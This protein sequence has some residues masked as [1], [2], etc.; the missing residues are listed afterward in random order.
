VIITELGP[1]NL[2]DHLDESMVAVGVLENIRCP[3]CDRQARVGWKRVGVSSTEFYCVDC[4]Y[5]A[6]FAGTFELETVIPS[7]I[8]MADHVGGLSLIA[9]TRLTEARIGQS[10]VDKLAKIAYDDLVGKLKPL[11]VRQDEL[12]KA[13][14][15]LAQFRHQRHVVQTHIDGWRDCWKPECKRMQNLFA[16]RVE[17]DE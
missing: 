7:G 13:L 5:L 6:T 2:K 9:Q 3:E 4:G 15:E 14:E 17:I 1:W 10:A 12:E 16:A 11:I 8:C